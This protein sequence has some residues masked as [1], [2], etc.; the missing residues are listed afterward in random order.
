VVPTAVVGSAALNGLAYLRGSFGVWGGWA[1]CEEQAAAQDQRAGWQGERLED[2]EAGRGHLGG[3]LVGAPDRHPPGGEQQPVAGR[4]PDLMGRGA[5]GG[6]EELAPPDVVEGGLVGQVGGVHAAQLDPVGHPQQL[7]P[8]AGLGQGDRVQLHPDRGQPGVGDQE[9]EQHVADPAAELQVAAAVGGQVGVQV[10]GEP[11][12][13]VHHDLAGRAEGADPGGGGHRQGIPV[14]LG[15][16]GDGRPARPAQGGQAH[17]GAGQQGGQD[18]ADQVVVADPGAVFAG[19]V[20]A[21]K[22]RREGPVAAFLQAAAHLVPGPAALPG[23]MDEH[24]RGH[25][26]PPVL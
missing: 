8:A 5:G 9:A 23:A 15:G 17:P 26:S 2:L 6:E 12:D 19:M 18:G 14:R 7:G 20:V 21:G 22:G 13:G 11:P 24:E 4:R 25:V 3:E 1:P 10:G 16:V